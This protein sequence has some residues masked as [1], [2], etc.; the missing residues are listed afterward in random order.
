MQ[1]LEPREVERP[2]HWRWLKGA[3]LLM[4]RCP[5]RFGALIAVLAFIDTTA[6]RH[7]QNVVLLQKWVDWLGVACLP[8]LW[9]LVSAMARGADYHGQ[10]WST[11]RDF[12]RGHAWRRALFAGFSSLLLIWTLTSLLAIHWRGFFDP[13]PGNLLNSFAEQ[14]SI[15]WIGFGLCYFPLLVF[16]PQLKTAEV[17]KLSKRADKLNSQLIPVFD[18]KLLPAWVPLPATFQPIWV[19]LPIWFPLLNINLAALLIE[20]FLSYGITVAAWLVYSGVVSYVAYKDIFERRPLNA[21]EPAPGAFKPLPISI[22][23]FAATS[24][25]SNRP[26]S[27][28]P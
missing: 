5:F 16:F 20:K 13:K 3:L 7:L 27:G 14:C 2:F 22:P 24:S 21:V 15:C 12:V 25:S 1:P 4:L 28:D 17:V 19:P 11:L 10:T 23:T 26:S 9:A 8:A 6:E 18:R